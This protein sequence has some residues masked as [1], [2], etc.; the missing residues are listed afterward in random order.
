MGGEHNPTCRFYFIKIHIRVWVES[1]NH[2][3]LLSFI[4][5]V[6][7]TEAMMTSILNRVTHNL[8]D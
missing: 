3:L 1:G 4:V 5:G 6:A 7:D 8:C 2:W